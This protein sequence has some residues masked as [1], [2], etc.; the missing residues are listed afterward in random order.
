[1][2]PANPAF[3]G[4]TVLRGR[5][6]TKRVLESFVQALQGL[7]L[8]PLGREVDQGGLEVGN[9]PGEGF[10][11]PG[12]ER[13][14]RSPGGGPLSGRLR[15]TGRTRSPDG[16]FPEPP[17]SPLDGCPAERQRPDFSADMGTPGS[18]GE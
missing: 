17:E 13:L 1:M 16:P 4:S 7:G 18:K 3:L 9:K 8:R 5:E 15:L 12:E 14:D 11:R 2:I 6:G 10:G